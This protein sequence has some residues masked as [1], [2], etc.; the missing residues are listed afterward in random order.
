MRSGPH[1]TDGG[2][3]SGASLHDSAE[4]ARTTEGGAEHD[5]NMTVLGSGEPTSVHPA[6]SPAVGEAA[7]AR[8]A[9]DAAAL[10]SGVVVRKAVGRTELRSVCDLFRHIWDDDPADPAITPLL[11]QALEFAGN[12][13]SVADVDERLVG[14]C[15]AFFGLTGDGWELHSHIA[16]VTSPL[17]GRH[18]GFALKTHQRAWALGRGIN[19]ISWTFDPLIRRNATFN[20]C[21][22]AARPRTYLPDF[23]GPMT[24]GI[25][26]GDETDRLLVDWHLLEPGVAE[27][28]VGRPRTSDLDAL[29][30]AGATVGLSPDANGGPVLGDVSAPTVLIAIPDDI[31]RLRTVD[32]SRAMAWRLSIRDVLGGL[33]DEGAAITGFVRSGWYV[34]ERGVR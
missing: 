27:A 15:V 22:L 9:A 18:V 24:D 28:C 2:V 3:Q 12:Y 1:G 5:V 11:L 21:K 30:D 16:G 13:V 29:R 33:I 7:A 6:G 32:P 10:A 31:E 23:Y 26:A 20:L 25:N 8:S 4:P 14:A 19:R 34:V 17:Q